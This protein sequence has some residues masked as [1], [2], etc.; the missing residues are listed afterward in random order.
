MKQFAGRNRY[1]LIAISILLVWLLCELY[2]LKENN[3]LEESTRIYKIFEKKEKRIGDLLDSIAY[4]LAVNSMALSD[5]SFLRF[6]HHDDEG[7]AVAVYSGKSLVFWS[8]SLIAFPA[9][10]SNFNKSEGL[11]HFPTGWYYH[12][13]RAAGVNTIRGFLLIKREFPYRNRYIRSTFDN[14]FRLS[15]DYRVQQ[16]PQSDAIN[17][18]KPNGIHLFSLTS[19]NVGIRQTNNSDLT[20][21]LCFALIIMILAQ[22]NVWLRYNKRLPPFIKLTISVTFCAFIFLI[23]NGLKF[24]SSLYQTNLFSPR[25]FA[26][27]SWLSSLGEFMLLSILMF[28]IAQA[29]FSLNIIDKSKTKSHL[30]R[31][32]SFLLPAFFF[33]FSVLLLKVMILNSRISLDFFSDL[34]FSTTNLFA[35]LAISLQVIGFI[36]IVFRLRYNY[37]KDFVG[38][39]FIAALLVSGATGWLIVSLLCLEIDWT[40]FIFYA[41]VV[42]IISRFEVVK[43]R[44]NKYT[45]LLVMA[46]ASAVYVNLYAQ[47]LISGKKNKVLD[48]WAVKLSSERDSGAEIFLSELD[49]KL[50]KDTIVQ[51]HLSPPYKSLEL[52]FQNNYFT[53]FWRNYN[54]QITVCTP[55]DSVFS[56]DENLKYPC[57]KFFDNL[58]KTKGMLVSGSNFYFMDR[59]NGRI[60]YL[61]QLDFVN[62]VKIPVKVF[63]ELNSKV[64]PEGKGYPE[65]LLD[66]HAS[67][68]SQDGDFCYAKYFDGELVDRGGDYQYSMK[69]PA[70][71]AGNDEYFRYSKN[72]YRHC[73][74][75]RNQ[76]SYVIASYPEMEFYERISTFP[77]LFLL[78][79]LMGFVILIFNE[80]KFPFQIKKLD[81]RQKIQL[82]LI[83]SLLGIITIIGLGLIIYNSNKLLYTLQGNLNEKLKSV[84]SELSMRIDQE[85]ELNAPIRDFINDQLIVLSD[86]IR[87]DINLYDLNGRLFATSR[88]EIFDRGLLSRRID[89]EAYK[90]ISVEHK[91]LFLHDENLGKMNFFS[92][93][94][95]VYNQH[96]RLIGYL[97]LPYFTWQEDFKKQVS[98]FIVAFSNL[99]ILLIIISLIVA[100]IISHKLTAPLLQIEKYLKGIQLGKT[101]AKIEYSGEDEIGRLAN[102]YNK[103]VDEL[104]IS[105]ELLARSERES[106]WQEMARQVAHEINNPLT[107]MKLSIQYLQRIKEQNSENFDD[108]FSRVSRTLVE[109][110][111]AL[112]LIASSFS[113]FAKMPTI[114]DELI[115]LGEK[116]SEVVLLF[117]NTNMVLVSFINQ[118]EEIVGVI[119][120]KDQLGRAVIN[121]IKN[122]IQAIPKDRNGIVKVELSSD[123]EWAYISVKDN[124]AG[125]PAGLHDKLF[126]PSFTTKSSGMGLGLAI[127]KRII[128]NFKGELSYQSVR[129]VET[130]F[131]IKLPLS[132]SPSLQEI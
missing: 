86:I 11:I 34:K 38:Y 47:E 3:R 31:I 129:D 10:D 63:I 60:S 96:N 101:N 72:G 67:R 131:T 64:I 99:Y 49:S 85:T 39:Q 125:I 94:S 7:L 14:E 112:S 108:Y 116:L 121:L 40:P 29:F 33:A 107:P 132:N 82:T 20:A 122:G 90:A 128:E 124:G 6:F 53:G 16:A 75:C 30:L 8:S 37:F 88:S 52:Y 115:D 113:D 54:L 61:G 83:I 19:S 68:E 26:Y 13:S 70:T 22:I 2:F 59:V 127:A 114:N 62:S 92:A 117:E 65:L 109:Q 130:T 79:Y 55:D 28:H 103:K 78:F 35:F 24:P 36:I 77:Y 25:D 50:Q 69:L 58:R 111:D 45:F 110:I 91:T 102:E 73:A 5:W 100:V 81:F 12:F 32:F 126:E 118:S 123:K 41:F 98:D 4:H 43:I 87:A 18:D 17:I 42:V 106:A 105:V 89:P 9:D 93:Y 56:T 71:I 76:N 51:S 1:M 80:K 95:P 84:S 119:A 120:D 44:A 48:L 21:F 15:D 66:E 104:A 27:S 97:N 74:Y 23:I 46:S 57:I